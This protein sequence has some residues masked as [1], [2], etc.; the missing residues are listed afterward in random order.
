MKGLSAERLQ[1]PK[2]QSSPPRAKAEA[3]RRK[4]ERTGS[5]VIVWHGFIGEAVL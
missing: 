4:Q 5:D 1:P 2:P 3:G